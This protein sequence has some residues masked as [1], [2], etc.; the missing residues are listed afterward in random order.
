MGRR[1]DP[2]CQNASMANVFNRGEHI[3]AL[4]ETEG[5]QRAVAVEYVVDGLL[6]GERCFYVVDSQEALERFCRSLKSV[7]VD[8]DAMVASG[9]LV[10]ATHAEAH[11]LG[12][13]FDCERMISFLNDA[14][15]SAL[16][17]GFTGLR[18]CG[19]MSWLLQNPPGASQVIEYEA[20]LN[21]LFEGVPACGMC[22]YDRHQLPPDI[23]DHA[24]ATHSSA[25]ID[26]RHKANPFY[27]P[28]EIAKGRAPQPNDL[29]WK[30][31]ELRL[32]R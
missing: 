3:C 5:E 29:S 25:T 28:G 20:I 23:V 10:T 13:A 26:G 7:G 1:L 21:H 24:L 2:F 6:K 27:K 9:A 15:E 32:R 19:D 4:Y 11:L 14:V 8:V 31:S 16:T 30:I 12:G 17:A 18:T 22:Q